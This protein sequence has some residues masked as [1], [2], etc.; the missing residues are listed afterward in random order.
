MRLAIRADGNPALG[1][2]HLSRCQA[3]AAGAQRRQHEICF[4]SQSCSAP[5]LQ[6]YGVPFQELPQSPDIAEETAAF[7]ALAKHWGA[8]WALVD[9]YSLDARCYADIHAAMRSIVIDDFA[10]L[11][12]EANI[13]LNA[14][15]YAPWLDYSAVSAGQFLLGG[16]YA[17]LR[18]EFLKTPPVPFH[19]QVKRVLVTM[20]GSDINQ[21]TPFV[22]SALRE[23]QVEEIL[24]IMGACAQCMEEVQSAASDCKSPVRILR[25]PPNIA[26]LFASCDFA[27]S[28]AGSTVYELCALGVPAILIEQAENQHLICAYFQ[29]TQYL[30]A[31]GEYRALPVER[32]A[33]AAQTLLEDVEKR[34]HM[35]KTIQSLVSR[36]GVENILEAMG[37]FHLA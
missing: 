22:L 7:I 25:A 17:I 9:T 8:D 20:G 6:Q 3:I 28:A 23:I 29:Q 19:G 16:Q 27:I 4:F 32:L 37:S 1:T 30:P 26:E 33:S 10:R 36:S 21:Y 14:N 35:H 13:L 31:L 15:L 24:V 18:D 11:P 12:Y 2:G 5:W 34:R